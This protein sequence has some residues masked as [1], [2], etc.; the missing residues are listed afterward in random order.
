VAEVVERGGEAG[1]DLLRAERLSGMLFGLAREAGGDIHAVDDED[2]LTIERVEPG[3]RHFGGGVGPLE[4]PKA[5]SDLARVGWSFYSSPARTQQ[6]WQ[7]V[8]VGAFTPENR[9]LDYTSARENHRSSP[10][11]AGPSGPPNVT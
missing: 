7:L 8:E 3:A 10:T 9:R 1:H 4:V 6:G 2:Y 5:A 11:S